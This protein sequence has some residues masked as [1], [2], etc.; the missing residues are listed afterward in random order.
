MGWS[1]EAPET[2]FRR[3][4]NFRVGI[5]GIRNCRDRHGSA[6]VHTVVSASSH[7][8]PR[9]NL[10]DRIPRRR[11][12]ESGSYSSELVQCGF[13]HRLRLPPVGRSLVARRS[14]PKLPSEIAIDARVDYSRRIPEYCSVPLCVLRGEPHHNRAHAYPLIGQLTCLARW[15]ARLPICPARAAATPASTGAFGSLRFLMHSKKF[16]MCV[17]V[18]SR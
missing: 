7:R 2:C 6:G 16:S 3:E 18:P 12:R 14:R 10:A 5:S 13:R 8:R 1:D 17:I 11:H 9:S 4:I 15:Y